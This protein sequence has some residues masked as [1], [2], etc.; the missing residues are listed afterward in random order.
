MK[1]GENCH[2]SRLRVLGVVSRLGEQLGENTEVG[3]HEM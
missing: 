3:Q 2:K 1:V